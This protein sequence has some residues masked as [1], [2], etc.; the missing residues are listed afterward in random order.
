M[1]DK[2]ATIFVIDMG[3][4]IGEVRQGREQSDLDWSMQYVWD[5]IMPKVPRFCDAAKQGSQRT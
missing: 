3:E 1:A 4:S 2:E 5:R